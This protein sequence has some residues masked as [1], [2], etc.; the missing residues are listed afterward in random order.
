MG[1]KYKNPPVVEAVCEFRFEPSG[2]WDL[3]VPGLVYEK[4]KGAFPKRRAAKL[5][6]A[7]VEVGQ[8]GVEQKLT[9]MEGMEFLRDD[10]KAF[11]RVAQDML[12]VH[13]LRPYP[14]WPQFVPL[15]RQGFE[16]F[17]EVAKPNGLHRIGLRYVNR[18]EIPTASVELEEYFHFHPSVGPDLP[19]EYGRFLVAIEIAYDGQRDMLRLQAIGP[20]VAPATSVV[21]I[22]DLDYFLAQ[23]GGIRLNEVFE[24]L[25]TAH[26]RVE[27]VFEG[28]ITDRLRGI[29][30]EI[31]T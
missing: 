27:V 19:Q 17:C 21:A 15:I 23:P 13:Q 11:V 25:Q 12:S 4:L 29:F 24:W 18:I 9:T 2:R 31:Q 3:T 1:K 14:A 7:S 26:T 6:E 8:Q 5:L 22:L 30:E 16:A 28:C 20:P 10:E